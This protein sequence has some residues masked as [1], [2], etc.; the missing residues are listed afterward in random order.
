MGSVEELYRLTGLSDSP[1]PGCKDL[2]LCFDLGDQLFMCKRFA[3][4]LE[5]LDDSAPA[6]H[7]KRK[8]SALRNTLSEHTDT[9][10]VERLCENCSSRSL[11]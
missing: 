1:S 5:V 8:A 3:E 2:L 6:S 10:F 4:A 11:K 9:E 7:K